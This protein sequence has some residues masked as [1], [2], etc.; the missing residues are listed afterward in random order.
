MA[1]RLPPELRDRFVDLVS[2]LEPMIVAIAGKNLGPDLRAKIDAKDVYQSAVERTLPSAT[3][4]LLADETGFTSFLL[5]VAKNIVR[6]LHDSF[7]RQSRD[8]RREHALDGSGPAAPS[9]LSP[10]RVSARREREE[11]VRLAIG[12]LPPRDRKIVEAHYFDHATPTEIATRLDMT[13]D[14]VRKR[15]AIATVKLKYA[16]GSLLDFLDGKSP[17]PDR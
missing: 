15:L 16:V 7:K 17:E 8:V 12:Q 14:A 6:D 4:A 9:T 5:T 2:R 11:M 1:A 13:A 3:P 10:S